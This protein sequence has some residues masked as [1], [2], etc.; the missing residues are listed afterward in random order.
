MTEWPLQNFLWQLGYLLK[1]VRNLVIQL[2]TYCFWH[3]LQVIKYITFSEL[4]S[5][6]NPSLICIITLFVSKR[7]FFFWKVQTSQFF[8]W[9]PQNFPSVSFSTRTF[10]LTSKYL[11][12]FPLLKLTIATSRKALQYGASGAKNKLIFDKMCL[13]FEKAARQVNLKTSLLLPY[14]WNIGL[15]NLS[16]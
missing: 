11:R 14:F 10:A 5:R 6:W 1:R 9:Q 3:F 12:L 8:P 16:R 4:Q 7:V 15:V 13:S 2:P